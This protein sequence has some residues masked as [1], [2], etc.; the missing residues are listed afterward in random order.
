[1]SWSHQ[2]F[3][4]PNSII[5]ITSVVGDLTMPLTG[6]EGDRESYAEVVQ[7]YCLIKLSPSEEESLKGKLLNTDEEGL[8]ALVIPVLVP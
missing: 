4:S 5:F 7:L 3:F 2:H 8:L 1:M 6:P